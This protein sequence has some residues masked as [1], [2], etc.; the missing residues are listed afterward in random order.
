MGN[1][2]K[3]LIDLIYKE[4]N[5]RA[6]A[7]ATAALDKMTEAEREAAKAASS[8]DDASK[9]HRTSLVEL[10]AGFD[11]AGQA[12]DGLKKVWDFAK[13]G[14][15]LEFTKK[16]F[17]NLTDSIGGADSVLKELRTATKGTRSDMELIGSATDFM[18]LGLAKSRDEVVR[19]TRVAGALNM[20][21]NQLVLTLANK[22]TMRFDQ[23]G[24]SVDGF[25]QRVKELTKSGLDANKAF[26]QAFLEQA[27]KQIKRVGDVADTTAGKMAKFE[28]NVKNAGDK[29]KEF[30]AEG[31]NAGIDILSLGAKSIEAYG[32]SAGKMQAEVFAG[33][34]TLD[35]YNA[36]LDGL[37]GNLMA[38]VMPATANQQKALFLLTQEQVRATQGAYGLSGALDESNRAIRA[39]TEATQLDTAAKAEN[40]AVLD[41]ITVGMQ[42]LTAELI[43]NKAAQGLDADAALQLG[44]AMGVLNENTIYVTQRLEALRQK[45]DS[46]K[47]GAIDAA[48]AA[49]GYT[50]EVANLRGVIDSLKDKTVRVTVIEEHRGDTR[51]GGAIGD[52]AQHGANFI[53]PSGYPNDTFPLRV[54]SGERV[55]V[56]PQGRAGNTNNFNMTVNAQNAPNVIDEFGLMRAMVGA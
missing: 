53:V 22:T 18:S 51:V 37:T 23:L 12:I 39:T 7:E 27:E 5:K 16:K 3:I 42:S 30:F 17:D 52:G 24:V 13:E 50:R 32:A 26:T 15:Q 34:M 31:V 55:I 19:L 10:K 1:A 9:K 11:L 6:I 49:A 28:A 4:E 33:R 29:L 35:E 56:I 54:T 36:A 48:E 45:Y 21:M 14:A 46:N 20:D 43:Y 8:A 41:T 38:A 2:N 25:D 40:K 47:D 44:L